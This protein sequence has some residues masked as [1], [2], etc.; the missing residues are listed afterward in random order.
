MVQHIW[1]WRQRT[2]VRRTPLSLTNDH[3]AAYAEAKRLS[4][5]T[6]IRWKAWSEEDQVT[7]LTVAQELQLGENQLRDFLDWLEEIMARDGGAARDLL[8]RGEV[9]SS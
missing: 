8:T 5:Q 3:I 7:L 1:H 9:Q 6:L 2:P 4:P